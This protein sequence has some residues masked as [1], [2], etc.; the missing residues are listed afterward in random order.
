MRCGDVQAGPGQS[1]WV[2]AVADEALGMGGVGCLEHVGTRA[3]DAF[4]PAD[5]DVGRGE[6]R[7]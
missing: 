3:V 1:W 2:S 5:V 4:A 6:N 7:E